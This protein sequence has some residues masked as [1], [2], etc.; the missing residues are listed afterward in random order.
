MAKPQNILSLAP[1]PKTL[2]LG[3][4]TPYHRVTNI[5]GYFQEF[6]NLAAANGIIPTQSL[7]I[8]L[9]EI[10]PATFITSGKLEEVIKLCQDHAIERVIISEQLTGLQAR[11]LED[12]LAAE[13]VDRTQLILEIF[14]KEARSAEG[15][16]QVALA[17][18]KHRKTRLAGKGV[19]LSQQ[20]GGAAS[21]AGGRGPG[22]TA[23]EVEKLHLERMMHK[24]KKELAHIERS[25]ATQRK[26]RL[27]SGIPLVSLIGY[28]NAGKSTILNTLT[29]SDVLAQ[30]RPFST[31]DT[32]T[33]ELFIEGKKKMLISDTVGFI[34]QL[35][36]QLINAFKATLEE[37]QYADLLLHVVDLTDPNWE[38]QIA[39]VH[40][41]LTELAVDKPMLYVFNKADK[42]SDRALFAPHIARYLPHVIVS[43]LSPDGLL[44]LVEYLKQVTVTEKK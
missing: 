31:L 14:E 4:H 27:E 34:Q 32:T 10:S 9:R 23:K 22:Q 21:V 28:T 29:K 37:L 15:K 35:P 25:R 6:V 12:I 38:A 33:R 11:N 26:R 8:R 19:Y 39:V 20:A 24:Y 7:F 44:P 5:E 1:Q 42:I 30:D 17:L 2:L 36:H 13:V 3:I 40:E 18:F 16:M 43:A 41:I